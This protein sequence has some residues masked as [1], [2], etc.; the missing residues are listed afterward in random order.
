MTMIPLFVLSLHVLTNL[1]IGPGRTTGR[2]FKIKGLLL[3]RPVS[4]HSSLPCPRRSMSTWMDD[5]PLLMFLLVINPGG[6]FPLLQGH[7]HLMWPA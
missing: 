5:S 4:V 6:Q 1:L 2:P 7:L 3:I